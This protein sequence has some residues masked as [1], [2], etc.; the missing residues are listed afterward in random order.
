MVC[1]FFLPGTKGGEA[2]KRRR[3]EAGTH[4]WN[5]E[6][7]WRKDVKGS[8]SLPHVYHYFDKAWMLHVS[9]G[10]STPAHSTVTP[11]TSHVLFL[12]RSLVA[13]NKEYR[14]GIQICAVTV[15]LQTAISFQNLN[16][17]FETNPSLC[18]E[19]V[20]VI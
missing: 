17:K 9:C 1:V 15:S 4:M 13:A 16:P 8:V 12:Y 14:L 7:V 10:G 6:E 5:L 19:R 2:S 11:N 18:D 20:I 3:S